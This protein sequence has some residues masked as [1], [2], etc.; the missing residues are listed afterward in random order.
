M[1][2]RRLGTMPGMPSL[3]SSVVTVST[4][5][6]ALSAVAAPTIAG[7]D[8]SQSK[9][10]QAVLLEV[11]RDLAKVKS[12][13]FTA[14]QTE[15]GVV[16]HMAGDIFA[17]GAAGI[18]VTEGKGS[19]RLIL[20]RKAAYMKANAV[21]W[22]ANGAGKMV[23]AKIAGRWVEV[24]VSAGDDF[25][26]LKDL[27]P[28]HL[29]SCVTRGL[30][31]VSNNGVKTLGGRKVIVLE[32]KG[33][34]PGSTPGLLYVAAEGPALPLREVQTGPRRPGGKV[35]GRCSDPNDK[36]TKSEVTFSRFDRVPPLKAPKG[37]LLLEDPGTTV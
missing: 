3:R 26:S 24:P 32:S 20:L 17:S 5:L 1:A 14:T 13:H 19:A 12:F 21:Y 6:L 11:Q 10:A 28:K 8:E 9:S 34:R 25:Q 35:D 33:D 4:S 31:T 36:S 16:S 22:R 29:A 2:P 7:G 27:M 37:A 15:K 23:A 30:G 18:A